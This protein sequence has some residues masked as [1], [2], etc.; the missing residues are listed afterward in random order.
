M[1]LVRLLNLIIYM[2][3]I[4]LACIFQIHNNVVEVDALRNFAKKLF[5]IFMQNTS[6][7]RSFCVVE[8]N[9]INYFNA[10]SGEGASFSAVFFFL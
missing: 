9:I 6:L 3:R 4:F 5:E 8:F 1:F 10:I 2:F 7:K